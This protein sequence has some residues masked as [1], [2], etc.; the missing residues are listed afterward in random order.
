MVPGGDW[1]GMCC[2]DTRDASPGLSQLCLTHLPQIKVPVL[3]GGIAGLCSQQGAPLSPHSL[4]EVSLRSRCPVP[5]PGM[6]RAL[7]VQGGLTPQIPQEGI[8]VSVNNCS[9][10]TGVSRGGE[11]LCCENGRVGIV[12]PGEGEALGRAQEGQGMGGQD[13]EWLHCQRDRA[14][15]DLGQEFLLGGAQS[16][17]G[18]PIQK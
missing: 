10:A 13:R 16:S 6:G 17:W 2:S 15:W 12:Q 4:T 8:C 3:P 1:A 5:A 18:C 14:G 9:R 7:G 11:Q